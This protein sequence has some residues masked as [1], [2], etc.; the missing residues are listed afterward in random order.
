[1]KEVFIVHHTREDEDG[2][3]YVKLIG[4]YSSQERA[5]RVVESYKSLPGFCDCVEGFSISEYEVDR[6]NWTEGFVNLS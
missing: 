3:E 1:M 5:E 4:V 2:C 6:N